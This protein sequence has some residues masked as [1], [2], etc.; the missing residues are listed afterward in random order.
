MKK[1]Y[2]PVLFSDVVVKIGD[3]VRGELSGSTETQEKIT[4]KGKE[5]RYLITL[6]S[7]KDYYCLAHECLHLVK[8]IFTDR[9]IP[10]NEQ[11]DEMIAYYQSYWIKRIWR[12][13]PKKVRNEKKTN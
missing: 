5:V 8:R 10:F 4:K 13:M 1:F 3:P 6:Q 11:N 9:G 12:S 2:E 7:N